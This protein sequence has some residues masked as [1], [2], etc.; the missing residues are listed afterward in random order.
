[1]GIALDKI[2]KIKVVEYDWKDGTH[3]IGIIAEELAKISFRLFQVNKD[4]VHEEIFDHE[5]LD[6]LDG[7]NPFQTG[8]ELR[9]L[10]GA[11]L[12]LTGNSYWLLD[13]V[14]KDTDKPKAIFLLNPSS[15]IFIMLVI[16]L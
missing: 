7:V 10:T 15:V 5:L 12:E 14:E 4:G 1:M 6:L 2:N 3:D 13:G 11:H 16:N 9:Y 8:Y